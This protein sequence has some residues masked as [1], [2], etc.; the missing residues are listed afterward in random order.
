MTRSS[1]A[2]WLPL[3]F[4]V[5][6]IATICLLLLFA[7]APDLRGDDS[8]EADAVSRSAVGFAGLHRLLELSGIPV[9]IDHGAALG[10]TVH[11][12]LT[13]LTPTIAIT[14]QDWLDYQEH[15]PVLII[16]PKWTVMPMPLK[17][18]WVNKTGALPPAT[19]T[20]ILAPIA[21]VQIAQW[22][23]DRR[24][25]LLHAVLPLTGL[26]PQLNGRLQQLQAAARGKGVPLLRLAGGLATRKPDS[27]GVAVL[28]RLRAGD[29][30]IYVL[31]EPDLMNN[32]GL[33]DESTAQMALA[34]VRSLRHGTSAVR[35]DVTLNGM[36]REPSLL[37]A[38]VEPP[39]RGASICALLAAILMALHALARFGAA[40]AEGKFAVR[41]KTALANNTA[42]LV[43]MMRR[44]AGM[45]ARYVQ[46]SRDMVLA[47]LGRRNAQDADAVLA[48]M[49]RR[50]ASD[51]HYAQL[52]ADAALAKNSDD[53]IRI[54]AMAHAWRGK[55]T[56]EH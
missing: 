26:P 24:D 41:G 12:S 7:Y 6:A 18:S 51:I 45:A 1:R 21:D 11:P 47:R 25:A 15:G 49:E 20:R 48:V 33:A 40:A 54:A 46:A 17:D 14:K 4:L 55:I 5:G 53:L 39:F 50:T 22:P 31:T 29:K 27:G 9:E 8:S 28:V 16:L 35:M 37:K 34:I 52:A 42:A 19:L 10:Q 32:H 30:P 43:H 56:G 13:I 2:R 23:G 38:L 36:T 44:E 3:L